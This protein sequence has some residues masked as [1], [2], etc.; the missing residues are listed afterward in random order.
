MGEILRGA[1]VI[2]TTLT[3]EMLSLPTD[4]LV[5]DQVVVDEASVMRTSE[6][7]RVMLRRGRRIAFVGD[8]KQLPPVVVARTARTKQWLER[9][10]FQ[11]A[12]LSDAGQLI[13][14]SSILTRQHRMAPPIRSIVSE[15]FYSGRL[16]DGENAPQIGRVLLVDSSDTRARCSREYLTN[17]FSRYNLEHVSIGTSIVDAVRHHQKDWT[18]RVMSPFRLQRKFYEGHHRFSQLRGDHCRVGTIHSSQGSEAQ[19]VVVDLTVADGG[20]RSRF[21]DERY[22]P[23]LPNLLNVAFSRAQVLLVI[24]AHRR[25]LREQYEGLL[26][27]R[28]VEQLAKAHPVINA[29]NGRMNSDTREFLIANG[30]GA[31]RKIILE[32]DAA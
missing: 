12:G 29:G 1:K 21:L 28:L 4:D 5:F 24:I 25:H 16:T 10:P 14:G 27:H 30:W 26:V 22:T 9:T 18:I 3:M 13:P 20:T 2:A 11:L 32:T 15:Q 6:V 17:G 7:V 31:P 8:P 23:S 19:L